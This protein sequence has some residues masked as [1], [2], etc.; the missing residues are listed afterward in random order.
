MLILFL[1]IAAKPKRIEILLPTKWHIP[2][3]FGRSCMSRQLA[4]IIWKIILC[5]FILN[6]LSQKSEYNKT[7]HH[8]RLPN[9]VPCMPQICCAFPICQ[10]C[11]Y[12]HCNIYIYI[13]LMYFFVLF[14]SYNFWVHIHLKCLG[15]HVT[16]EHQDTSLVL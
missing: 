14:F 3:H 6:A 8:M 2:Y 9:T 16:K 13:Y 12:F 1:Y 7:V 11:W 15:T 4:T 5:N 10:F